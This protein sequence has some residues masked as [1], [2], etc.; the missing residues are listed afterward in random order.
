MC[1][2]SKLSSIQITMCKYVFEVRGKNA[3][4]LHQFCSPFQ[5]QLFQKKGET[6]W[7]YVTSGC[8]A[9][10]CSTATSVFQHLSNLEAPEAL[11]SSSTGLRNG[12]CEEGGRRGQQGDLAVTTQFLLLS[13]I[14]HSSHCSCLL[15]FL[16]IETL[17][18]SCR[19]LNWAS[20]VTPSHDTAAWHLGSPAL[21]HCMAAS[22]I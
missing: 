21:R 22:N 20:C 2:S 11:I 5:K 12:G 3:L 9:N 13:H 18:G 14:S 19:H 8:R 16:V 6:L 15:V 17:R 7:D 10:E 4:L 1:C